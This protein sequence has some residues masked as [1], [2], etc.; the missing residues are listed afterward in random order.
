[1]LSP[2]QQ[3]TIQV[4]SKIALIY[5][6]FIGEK[7]IRLASPI[8]NLKAKEVQTYSGE[9]KP[10]ARKR[11]STAVSLLNQCSPWKKV[12]SPVTGQLIDFKLSFIT[13][14]FP[15][16]RIV[17]GKEAYTSCLYP[18]LR[19]MKARYPNLIYV[20]KAEL[21]ERG[22][23]HYHITAN[24]CIPHQVIRQ[25][26][27]KVLSSGG[28]MADYLAKYGSN[29]APTSEIKAVQ[30]ITDIEAYL[31]KYIG[32][33]DLQGRSIEGKVWGCSA[34][35]QGRRYFSDVLNSVNVAAIELMQR[36][37]KAVVKQL[38]K[39]TI[40]KLKEG[41]PLMLLSKDQFAS[42]GNYLNDVLSGVKIEH[43]KFTKSL[44]LQEAKAILTE[45]KAKIYTQLTLK[46]GFDISL[47]S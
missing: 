12:P 11:L 31:V 36:S 17:P 27:N 14:T 28:Y 15:C 10:H 30:N 47:S 41:S 9:L 23:I 26:W 46:L 39:C 29:N 3:P 35:L 43:K 2:Q 5:N 4:R 33:P 20:Y 44:G 45:N 18:F 8:L 24:E 32:K 1:M 13:L 21:Q 42:Y 37:G 25:N 16:E 40:V 19:I 38:E 7:K 22:Q 6:Q 34:Q